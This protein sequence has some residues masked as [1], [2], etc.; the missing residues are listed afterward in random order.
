MRAAL[1]VVW[2]GT[3]TLRR[4]NRAD[5]DTGWFVTPAV[6]PR[7]EATVVQVVPF[8]DTCRSKSRVFQDAVSPPA[9]A[10]L[11]TM[12]ET[13]NDDPRSTCQNFVVPSE[14]HLSV[15]PP[16][17]LP[18]TALAGPSLALHD[19]SAVAGLFNATLTGPPPPPP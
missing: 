1:S 16:D 7:I 2:V 9:E 6:L 3:S 10:C 8:N 5:I 17:T 15:V 13:E 4:T 19:E 11:T 12:D 18:L 14:H